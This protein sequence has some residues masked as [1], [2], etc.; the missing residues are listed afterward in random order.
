MRN[1]FRGWRYVI[2]LFM[3]F[4]TLCMI[5]T[6][7]V[8]N[9]GLLTIVYT[10]FSLYYIYQARSFY[11]EGGA[12]NWSFPRLLRNLLFPYIQLDLLA[13]LVY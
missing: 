6:L 3:Q 9:S 7:S 12:K 4:F 13:Q 1:C 10:V 2:F 8:S 11:E 5:L